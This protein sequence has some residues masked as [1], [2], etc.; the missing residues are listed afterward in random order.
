MKRQLPLIVVTAAG[1]LLTVIYFLFQSFFHSKCDSIFE[2]TMDQLRGN[3][4]I[5]KTKGELV[6]GREKVQEL[7]EGSQKVAL[8]LKTCCI[9]Q[10]GGA[11]N[12]DQLQSCMNGARDYE[13]KV[14]QVTTIIKEAQVAMEQGNTQLAQQKTDQARQAASGAA[15]T[16]KGLGKT[17]ESL[18]AISAAGPTPAESPPKSV[19]GGSEQEPNNMIL[20]AN[21]AEMGTSIAGVIEPRDDLD[22][23]KLQYR[24][25]KK[26]RDIVAVHLENHSTTLQPSERL[27]YEDKSVARDW[28]GANAVG[29]D[30]DFSFSAEPGKSYY[31]AVAS[32]YS[33]TSGKY[34]LSVVP[35]KAYDQYEPNDDAFT[36]API[37][38]GQTFEANIMDGSDVDWYR[39]SG[40]N[41]KTVTVRLENQSKT[42][43]PSIRVHNADKSV[44]RD[45]ATPNAE[46]ADLTFSFPA[47]PG[48]DYFV[49][50]AAS[51]GGSAGKYK[52]TTR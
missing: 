39:L 30:F 15:S 40:I 37:K 5:I 43:Q 47:E 25:A 3:F 2:Q 34:T 1:I 29:A 36:A 18:R 17:A 7:T 46:G 41:A 20:Q 45:W 19:K 24:D 13:T 10:E 9:V 23:F 27:Y 50:V 51:Y 44:A 33:N 32:S 49:V 16:E 38:F 52:L 31:V 26:R 35:Q 42:L 21:V 12:A 28:M 4:E 48:Q 11:M 14:V 6:L 8:H 22:F